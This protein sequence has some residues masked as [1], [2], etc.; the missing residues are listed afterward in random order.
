MLKSNAFES[1]LS[2][3]VVLVAVSFFVFMRMQTGTGSLSAYQVT[4]IVPRA[5]G[6]STGTD[7]RIAGVKIGTVTALQLEPRTYRVAMTMDIRTDVKIPVDST[8]STTGGT[9]SSNYLTL[10]PGR[11]SR[12]VPPNGVL[13]SRK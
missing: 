9:M 3:A 12:S 4:A 11:D 13:Q 7:V 10:H 8:L 1:F 5:D 2:A 6:L